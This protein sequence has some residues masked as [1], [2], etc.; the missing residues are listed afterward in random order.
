M[1]TH[2]AIKTGDTDLV[3]E[4]IETRQIHVSYEFGGLSALHLAVMYSQ[5]TIV[6]LL[7]QAGAD[8]NCK[9]DSTCRSS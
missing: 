3:K 9:T 5:T 7:L 6:S 8:V 1:N 2:L 4:R